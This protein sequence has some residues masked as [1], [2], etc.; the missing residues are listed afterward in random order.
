MNNGLNDGFGSPP[1]PSGSTTT[2]LRTIIPTSKASIDELNICSSSYDNYTIILN[3]ILPSSSDIL[4]MRVA[5]AGVLDSTAGHYSGSTA[6][7]VVPFSGV[8]TYQSGIGI[9]VIL[10]L[11]NVNGTSTG[12]VLSRQGYNQSDATTFNSISASDA[13]I[14]ANKISGFSFFWSL[15]GNFSPTGKIFIYGYNNL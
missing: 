12:K 2:L 11:M 14:A 7:F 13:Y 8:N 5:V 10:T 9:S 6:Q 1:S 15:G 4:F 3:G